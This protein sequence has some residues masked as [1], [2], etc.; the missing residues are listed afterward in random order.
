MSRWSRSNQAIGLYLAVLTSGLFAYV[1]LSPWAHRVMRDGFLLG[2][3][4]FLGAGAMLL[5]ALAMIVDPLRREI[6]E[7]MID[8][9]WSDVYVPVAVVIGIVA[10]FSVMQ[11]I[12][13]LLATPV[14]LLAAMLWFGLR[15]LWLALS[16]A[17]AIA[18]GTIS[19][20]RCSA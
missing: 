12:G 20:S 14:F 7:P 16:L 15:P 4:P 6:P 5:C 11:R 9:R 13:F 18:V 2:F 19:C 3:F 1:W 17:V 10:Y 8:A